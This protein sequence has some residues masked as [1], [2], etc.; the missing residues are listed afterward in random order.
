MSGAPTM[1]LLVVVI[2]D[3]EKLDEI[4]SGFLELGITGATVVNSEGMGSVLSHDMPIF[5]GLETLIRGSRDQNRLLFSVIP[6][7]KV[8]PAVDLLQEVSGGLDRPATGIAFTVP[9]DAVFGLAPE[10]G[11]EGSPI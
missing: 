3:P 1:R 10:L 7:D 2:H 5:A 6:A 4:L 8:G 9:V 11:G